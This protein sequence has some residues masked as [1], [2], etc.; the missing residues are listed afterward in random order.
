MSTPLWQ[1]PLMATLED[2]ALRP[3]G[4]ALTRK[5]YDGL[6]LSPS[7]RVLDAGCGTGVTGEFLQ[8]E[9][10]VHVTGL[11]LSSQNTLQTHKRHIPVVQGTVEQLPFSDAA[12]PIASRNR[13]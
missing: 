11:D 6:K 12:F 8:Q 2:G 1:H 7:T 10:E 4:L 5:A 9:Y 3:G 13:R